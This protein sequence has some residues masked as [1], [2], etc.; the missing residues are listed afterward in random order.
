MSEQTC[1]CFQ[2][3][4]EKGATEWFDEYEKLCES[5][6][7]A[8]TVTSPRPD[9]YMRDLGATLQTAPSPKPP[10]RENLLDEWCSP[11]Q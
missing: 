5:Y 8:F 7:T 2:T 9:A 4:H 1:K 3:A 6:V 11:F 10:M